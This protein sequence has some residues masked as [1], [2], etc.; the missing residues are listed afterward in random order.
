MTGTFDRVGNTGF[1]PGTLPN[2]RIG[3]F[4][5]PAVERGDYLTG[6]TRFGETRNPRRR[7]VSSFRVC[8]S[9]GLLAMRP[10][11]RAPAARSR[12]ECGIVSQ[13]PD[14]KYSG[15]LR[16]GG[17]KPATLRKGAPF[18]VSDTRQTMTS[19]TN[20]SDEPDLQRI[21]CVAKPLQ[22][23]VVNKTWPGGC[24]RISPIPPQSSPPPEA[25]MVGFK[26]MAHDGL[27]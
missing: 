5:L 27:I 20:S 6:I 17:S 2:H 26:R 19:G 15:V 10:A 25:R 4:L 18:R 16:R 1:R 22:D 12:F 7:G 24:A 23:A 13:L 21:G 9:P 11:S 8:C 3:V 14:R